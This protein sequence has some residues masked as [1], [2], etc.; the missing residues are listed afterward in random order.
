MWGVPQSRPV[1]PQSGSGGEAQEPCRQALPAQVTAPRAAF[2]RNPDRSTLGPSALPTHQVT[3]GCF[4][5][6]PGREP[7]ASATARHAPGPAPAPANAATQVPR[8]THRRHP[9]PLCSQGQPPHTLHSCAGR[10]GGGGGD[11]YSEKSARICPP[12]PRT[13]RPEAAA[14][15]H[16]PLL[17]VPG[18]AGSSAGG[19]PESPG[20]FQVT[21]SWV[22]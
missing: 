13:S 7:P 16:C 2:P 5:A 1:T 11:F 20:A 22:K 18:G 19:S 15:L 6:P 21:R 8:Q 4:I 14:P 17:G 10:G 3:R 9:A 12:K